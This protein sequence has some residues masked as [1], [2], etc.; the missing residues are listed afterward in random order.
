MALNYI[1]KDN[2]KHI[3]RIS[4]NALYKKITPKGQKQPKIVQWEGAPKYDGET[5]KQ[6]LT[7]KER[8]SIK[9]DISELAKRVN[10]QLTRISKVSGSGKYGEIKD[11]AYKTAQN[12][13]RRLTGKS[14][15]YPKFP[16]A[17]KVSQSEID[18]INKQHITQE[19]KE[20][21]IA[22]LQAKYDDFNIKLLNAMLKYANSSSYSIGRLKSHYG[23]SAQSVN[24]KYNTNYTW[25]DLKN[26][27]ES[28]MYKKLKAAG[29]DSDQVLKAI[30]KLQKHGYD[31]LAELNI[32]SKQEAKNKRIEEMT[33]EEMLEYILD[34]DVLYDDKYAIKLDRA[35][36]KL[37][38]KK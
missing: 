13:I 12:D 33:T 30:G 9:E 23:K 21:K 5:R 34:N 7:E 37:D 27:T 25:L 18:R 8:Q 29:I 26:L 1:G 36:K 14:Q 38:N 6:V 22:R 4:V 19:Q 24:D 31:L 35:M 3:E 10:A 11:M 16:T 15:L 2:N 32:I 17:R 28:D 20:E